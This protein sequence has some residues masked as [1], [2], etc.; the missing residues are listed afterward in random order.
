MNKNKV[1]DKKYRTEIIN[2][3]RKFNPSATKEFLSTFSTSEL[4]R[5]LR[6]LTNS[7]LEEVK[8]YC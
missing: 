1:N 6:E 5:Y 8:V 4:N 2:T 7:D 3:I